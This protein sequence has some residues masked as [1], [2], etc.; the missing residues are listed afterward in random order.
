MGVAAV[1]AIIQAPIAYADSPSGQHMVAFSLVHVDND[2][3][4]QLTLR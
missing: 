1:A 4:P 2:S 3:T